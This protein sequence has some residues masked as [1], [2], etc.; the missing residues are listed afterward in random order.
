M[1]ET[2]IAAGPS[3]HSKAVA[4]MVVSSYLKLHL[5]RIFCRPEV[6]KKRGRHRASLGNSAI[7]RHGNTCAG[8][9]DCGAC[10]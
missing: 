5:V 8:R 1:S 2:F 4:G 3:D 7:S 9:I 10:G 6:G